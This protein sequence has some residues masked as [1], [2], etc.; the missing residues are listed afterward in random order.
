VKEAAVIGV[1][2]EQRKTHEKSLSYWKRITIPQRGVLLPS[3][4]QLAS[5]DRDPF[6]AVLR[7]HEMLAV[8][9]IAKLDADGAVAIDE[10]GTWHVDDVAVHVVDTTGAG[11]AMAGAALAAIASGCDI[12]T[13]TA[14]GVS[15]A[16]LALS[17]WGA[18]G[19]I[20]SRPLNRA[21]RGVRARR[22]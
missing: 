6:R 16:R 9:I 11:D 20:N 1:D 14:F 21:L 13:A 10:S 18:G 19:L 7:L 8:P 3:R 22:R 15:A 4:L 17:D 2:P 5:V 12:A